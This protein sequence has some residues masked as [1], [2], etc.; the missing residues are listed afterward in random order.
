MRH[1]SKSITP[2]TAGDEMTRALRFASKFLLAILGVIVV[3]RLVW[4]SFAFSR[5]AGFFVLAG[6]AVVLYLTARR[7]VR[8]LPSLL[9]FGI[10][11]S[12]IGLIT[13]HAPTNP[14]AAVSAEVA[15]LLVIFYT[16]GC[17]VS[18]HYDAAHLSVMDRLALLLYLFCMIWPAF[19][20]SNLATVTPVVAWSTTT[21]TAVLIA[22]F[23]V[24]RI[25]RGK[26]PFGA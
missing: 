20:S 11:N 17:I 4:A 3:L 19:A 26:E 13:H 21:G 22:S 2:G 7:W 18:Y 15:V 23:V 6:A 16:A 10:V 12:L 1:T 5:W 25:R 14:R 8:W 24:H 9:I